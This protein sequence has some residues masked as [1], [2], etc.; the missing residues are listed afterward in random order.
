[1]TTK[2]KKLNENSNEL[3]RKNNLIKITAGILVIFSLIIGGV[4]ASDEGLA[5]YYNFNFNHTF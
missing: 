2:N 3:E 1:M 5:T 4:S